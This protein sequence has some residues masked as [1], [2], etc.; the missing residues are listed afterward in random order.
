MRI[1]KRISMIMV[2]ALATLITTAQVTTSSISG[3]VK[4]ADGQ[5]IEG[6]SLV[7]VHTPSGTQ[8]STLAKKGGVF[9]LP[10]LRTGGP[11]TLKITFTGLKVETVNDIYLLLGEPYVINPTLI[12]ESKV[13]SEVVVNALK[14]KSSGDKSGGA[15][16]V[17]NQRMLSTMPTISRS[18]TDFTRV[19]PQANG[20]S[21]AGRDG[22]FNNTQVDGANLNNNFGLSSDPLPGGG[23]SPISIDAIEEVSVNIAPFDVRQ[24]GFTG[25]G[26]NAVTKSGT[27]TLKGTFYGLYRNQDYNGTNVGD[28]KLPAQ[29]KSSNKIYGATLGGAIIKNKLFF[30]GS[31]ENE[32]R[33]QP[34]ITFSPRGGSGAGNVSNTSV[35]SLNKF[36]NHLRTAYGY[37]PGSFDN[38]PNFSTKNTKILAKIDWNI[39]NN[40]KLT[41]KYS[42]LTSFNDQQ[43]NGSSVPN[44]PTFTPAGGG[45]ISR[46]PNNRF[47]LNS[48]SFSNSNY[49][50]K[51]VVRTG[52]LELNSSFG[53]K[54][55]NQFIAT[56][57]KIQ[58][59]RSIDG[60]FFPT[61]D[62]FNNNGQN[63]MSAGSDPFT[64]NNDVKNDVFTV[65]NNFTYYAGKHTITGGAS[66]EYQS[67]GNMFMPGS[68]SYYAFN[69]LN[70]FIT[71]RA[72]AAFSYTFSLDPN[73]PSVYA[74]D[75]KVGQLG[76]YA[77]DEFNVN[78]NFKLT[79]GIRIDKV[80]FPEAPLENPNVSAL[81]FP[82]RNGVPTNFKTSEWPK[83]NSVYFSPRIGFRYKIDD[84]NIVVRGGTGLFTG[85]IP[86]VYLTNMPGNSQMYQASQAVTNPA[87]LGNFLFNPNPDAYR[88]SFSPVAGVLPNNANVV[89][90]DKEF[91][92]P[93]IWRTNIAFDK[94][95]GN[96]WGLTVEALLTKDINA[97]IMRNAN[98][99][100][101]NAVISN[102]DDTRGRFA[103]TA[104]RRVYSNI[105]SAIILENASKGNSGSFTVQLTKTTQSGFSGMI[106]YTKSYAN[107][108]TA[109]P[110]SQAT[111]TW[112]SNPT[113]GTQNDQ[114]LFNSAYVNP[115][116]I[117]TS[118]SYKLNYGK[119]LA[120]T[121][122]LF[123][124]IARGNN[125]S[126]T[127]NGDINND[128]NN[129]SDLM[130]I[131]YVP[132]FVAQAA[133]GGN[134]ARSVAEQT[135]AWQQFVQNSPYLRKNIGKYAGRNEAY[136]PWVS[137]FDLRVVQDIFTNI[138]N[139][140]HTI[141]VTADI[142]NFGNMLFKSSG[143][144]QIVTTAQPLLFRGYD[145]QGR[146]TFNLQ[147]QGGQLVT[148]PW[149]DNLSLASTW[150]MQLGVRYIF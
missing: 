135:A 21:F 49:K 96:G 12:D 68:A 118:L 102:G 150:S 55:S 124:E 48:M 37:D 146:P 108:L 17:I 122:S 139:R 45:S 117:I 77:Q 14:K 138:G 72:P 32:E 73:K 19:T 8:Y 57:S 66:Y 4:T 145:A 9:T 41:L 100:N 62:I 23:A 29:V 10:G 137:R 16:T 15:S 76:I 24:S 134:P 88:G 148:K 127:Y 94:K 80:L 130:H 120:T 58:A 78:E 131:T 28:V 69:S 59:T 91:R 149:Q 128:G 79:Y 86:F 87:L 95:L 33:S 132:N 67:V 3:V 34:G 47:S 5:P 56:F 142:F 82:D 51:D 70:D 119:N 85:R 109:N 105:G 39:N 129:A 44:N 116:R 112:Q 43:L 54:F 89:L 144:R 90:M 103:T 123:G 114:Q 106:A 93:Q 84:E 38:F 7:A 65:T 26:I 11:Y 92:F 35:D 75:L 31:Y 99:R 141:Q 63:Y 40:H 111:S 64:R 107:E 27:N 52:S 60:G 50:F 53:G 136:L 20:T 42:D 18:I 121:F 22:R 2:A 133:S 143:V 110:G 46:L 126:Y 74:A 25:A 140:K 98:Q 115:D 30:F 81:S 36:A 101:T 6:A 104:D 113:T 97:V 61:I 71:N 1:F 83:Q 147:Q 13:L 125:F